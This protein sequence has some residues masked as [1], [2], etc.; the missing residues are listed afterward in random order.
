MAFLPANVRPGV[1]GRERFQNRG[2]LTWIFFG[3]LS[4]LWPQPSPSTAATSA[5]FAECR[6]C[7]P[8]PIWGKHPIANSQPGAYCAFGNKT[9]NATTERNTHDRN[10]VSSDAPSGKRTRPI[11]LE[12]RH[13]FPDSFGPG[14]VARG[15]PVPSPRLRTLLFQWSDPELARMA[16]PNAPVPAEVGE[17][18]AVEKPA[19]WP[20]ALE[21]FMTSTSNQAIRTNSRLSDERA[22]LPCGDWKCVNHDERSPKTNRFSDAV[23]SLR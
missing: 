20:R 16:A 11:A 1:F 3:R 22:S 23:P 6:F 5:R 19:R 9:N 21:N 17:S 12:R 14:N 18:S 2:L 8:S 7:G 4:R 15:L 10:T 13:F